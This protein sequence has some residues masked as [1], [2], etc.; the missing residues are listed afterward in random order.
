MYLDFTEKGVFQ[1][2][3]IKYTGEIIEEFPETI[4][5]SSPT[6]HNEHLFNVR[7][8]D[9]AVLLPE[10]QVVKFHRTTAQLLFLSTRARRDIQTAVS[11]LTTRV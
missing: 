11:F 5:K 2:E 9:E 4:T 6:P 10:E 7:E 3:M 1:I 8:L